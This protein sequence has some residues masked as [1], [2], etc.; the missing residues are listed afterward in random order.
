MP[1]R[2]PVRHGRLH[3]TK[4]FS[5]PGLKGTHPLTVYLPPDYDSSD[6][7][8]PVAYMFDGQ[9]L[10][11]DE[12]SF[13]GGWHLHHALDARVAR[14]RPVPIV[15]G[16]HHGGPSRMEELSPWTVRPGHPGLGDALLDW[17]VGPL[18]DMVAEDLRVLP[19]AEDTM[20]GGSSLGGL[21]ALYGFFRHPERFGAALCMSPSL[22]VHQGAVFSHVARSPAYGEPKIYL[23]CG[24]REAHGY[25]L[26]H[27]LWMVQLL[28]RKGFQ[29]G[30]H[31]LWRPDARGAHNERNWRRRLPRALKFI[32]G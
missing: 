23:D 17:V 27:A 4:A 29:R 10:F 28:E 6:E 1:P 20:I 16:I 25:A 19:T 32:Y 3:H 18:R 30:Q 7:R 14:R 8:Y 26:E 21:L 24:G 11:G 22:W 9:N 15:V 31:V 12:G 2:R 13:A 5:I